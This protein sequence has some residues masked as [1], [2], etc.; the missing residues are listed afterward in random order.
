[1]AE[2]RYEIVGHENNWSVRVGGETGM[3]YATKVAAF[4][5]AVMDANN[6]LREGHDVV[7]TVRGSAGESTL[8]NET[9][10]TGR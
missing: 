2:Y 5:A 1:M 7:V 3:G 10:P 9:Q 6:A 4:E 8:G